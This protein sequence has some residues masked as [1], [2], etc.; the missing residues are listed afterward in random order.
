[1]ANSLHRMLLGTASALVLSIGTAAA[2]DMTNTDPEAA[3]AVNDDKAE[4]LVEVGA[5][6]PAYFDPD[7]IGDAALHL[8]GMSAA[9][10]EGMDV[11]D[12]SGNLVGAVRMVAHSQTGGVYLIVTATEDAAGLMPGDHAVPLPQFDYNAEADALVVWDRYGVSSGAP[13]AGPY[14]GMARL[15]TVMSGAEQVPDIAAAGY[16]LVAAYSAPMADAMA[17]DEIAEIE[18]AYAVGTTMPAREAVNEWGVD[19]IVGLD[20]LNRDGD[21]IGTVEDIARNDQNQLFLIISLD[22]A[23]LGIGDS[24]RAV[25]LNAFQYSDEHEALVLID[26]SE[27]ALEAMAEFDTDTPGYT[28]IESDLDWAS[29]E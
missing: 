1:M 9:E 28:L 21:D 3:Q 7:E 22:D 25:R 11:Y 24:E 2:E 4:Q 14:G 12:Q 5:A 26:T 8:A 19:E 27:E 13:A 6:D 29:Y 15:Y 17:D 10:V 16:D 18:E 20:I 23:I